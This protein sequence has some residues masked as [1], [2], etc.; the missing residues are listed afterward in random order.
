MTFFI[1]VYFAFKKRYLLLT[2]AAEGK[3]SS[4]KIKNFPYTETQINTCINCIYGIDYKPPLIVFFLVFT[5]TLKGNQP[6]N[7]KLSCGLIIGVSK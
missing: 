5:A 2:H 4:C 7:S 6:E 3:K 1:I